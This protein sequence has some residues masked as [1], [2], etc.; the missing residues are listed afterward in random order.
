LCVIL[1]CCFP[2]EEKVGPGLGCGQFEEEK[3]APELMRYQSEEENPGS[4][5]GC[6]RFE[7]EKPAPDLM[8]L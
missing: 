2:P 4:G 8:W 5:L 3:A 1:F 6:C 7:E